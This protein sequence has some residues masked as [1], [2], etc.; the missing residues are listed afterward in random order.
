MSKGIFVLSTPLIYK[1]GAFFFRDYCYEET[2][3]I[4]QEFFDDILIL[5]RCRPLTSAETTYGKLSNFKAT[6]GLALPDYG[7]GG[8][9]GGYRAIRL[10]FSKQLTDQILELLKQ[11][12]YIH[13]EAP[14]LE[15]YV[16]AKIAQR[17]NRPIVMEMRGN[18]LLNP[19]YMWDRFGFKGLGYTKYFAMLSN[20]IR[21][22]AVA[23]LY[24]NDYLLEKYPV[25]GNFH[26]SIC[27]VRLS[28]ER[29][30]GP[31]E[32]SG[33]ARRFIYVGTLEKVKRV[34][35]IFKAL[36]LA[37]KKINSDWS[38]AVIG[39]GPERENLLK[40]AGELDISGHIHLHGSIPWDHVL[41]F[42]KESDLLF[43]A[44][45]SEGASRTLLEAMAT[46]L[47]VISTAVGLAPEL[48]D[49][50]TLVTVGNYRLFASRLCA[51]SADST[52][53]TILSQ[54]N[55]EK[56]QCFRLNILKD[57]RKAFYVQ[58]IELSKPR[59]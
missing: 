25:E 18:V 31:R 34:D 48:L 52:L 47:P 1:Q 32:F 15:A 28:D 19:K 44:S 46:G 36:Q 37:Q 17:I 9:I 33:P 55:W 4:C 22:N 38:L 54:Q 58:A 50:R 13:V 43:M 16:I 27:D 23:G 24:V 3:A 11:A 49:K 26:Q 51:I 56:A 21:H 45:T 12:E 10:L 30:T 6:L 40:L 8:F 7:S 42:Y 2:I 5:A 59:E 53:L 35:L 57:R 14:S 29:F 39:D 41:K 20:F